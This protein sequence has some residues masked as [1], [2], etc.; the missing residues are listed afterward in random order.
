VRSDEVKKGYR[1]APHRSLFYAMGYTPAELERPLIGVVNSFTEV[2]PGHIHLRDIAAAVKKGVIAGG[3]TPVEVPCIGICDGIAMD[4]GGMRYSLASRELIAD[5]IEAQ[6]NGHCFDGLVLITNCD[7]IVPGMLMAA[8]RLD[9]PAVVVSGGPMLAGRWEEKNIDVNSMFEYVGQ[10]K[11]GKITAAELAV[12]EQLACPGCGSC[13]GLFTANSMNCLTEAL[14]MGLPGNGTIPAAMYGKRI[15]LAKDAGQQVMTLLEKGI[16]ARKIMTCQAFTNAITVDMA[17]GGSSNTVLHLTA[18]ANEAGIKLELQDFDLISKRTPYLC[19]LS[20]A[21]KH[22][23]QD[24]N[25]AGGVLAVMSELA[26][27]D[28]L[29]LDCLTVSG[30]T[31]KELLTGV[32]NKRP[33]VLR[34]G[35]NPYRPQGGIAVLW[36][37]LAPDG[38]VVKEAAVAESM[39][40]FNGLARVFNGEEEAVDAIL[41]GKI[42]PGDVIVIRYEGPRGGPGMREM[43]TPTS[44][45]A[46]MGLAESVALITD[47]RFSGAT[48]GGCI[49]HVSPEAADGGPIALVEEGDSIVIDI[50]GRKLELLVTSKELEQRRQNFKP[51]PPKVTSGYL[52]RYAAQVSSAAQGAVLQNPYQHDNR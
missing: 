33:E 1:R 32:Y 35:A 26:K 30:K 41:A 39:L 27:L 13:A 10:Y 23:M 3:G 15:A 52:A 42:N 37:N 17:V 4:H 21:G 31:V 44:A 9:L 6:A 19:S 5:S 28:L 24:L 18:I 38:A 20:P 51:A 8:A 49:G 7:K 14:G 46:G 22:H 34:S 29:D 48:R 12:I 45:L 16:T 43:L 40:Q 25:D 50:P 36:G 47:G 2:I 11:S